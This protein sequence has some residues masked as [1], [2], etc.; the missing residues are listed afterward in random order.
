MFRVLIGL[1][2]LVHLCA[3]T[4]ATAAPTWPDETQIA[5]DSVGHRLLVF[6]HPH[7]RCSR[8]IANH[9]LGLIETARAPTK[10]TFVFYCPEG[11]SDKWAQNSVWDKLSGF[12]QHELLIDRGGVEAE[13]FNVESSGHCV[14]FD[15]G[16][17]LLFSGGLVADRDGKPSPQSVAT[18]RAHLEGRADERS[19]F[20]VIGCPIENG[21][22]LS[23]Y[24]FFTNYGH[25]MPRIHCLQTAQGRP[26]WP[27]ILV[28]I[29]LNVVILCG[30]IKIIRIWL[31][32][33]FAEERRDREP[34][35]LDLA[36]IF[37]FC[38]LSGYGVSTLI[39]FWPA[40]RLLAVLLL[41]LAIV[42][43]RFAYDLSPFEKS[44][45]MSR[46]GRKN[47]E[48]LEVEIAES[49]AREAAIREAY[50]ALQGIL[51]SLPS[52]VCILGV[53]GEII[54]ANA[55]SSQLPLMSGGTGESL[56]VNFLDACRAATGGCHDGATALADATEQIIREGSGSYNAEICCQ[57]G[58]DLL[59]YEVCVKPVKYHMTGATLVA[60]TDITKR[61]QAENEARA[62]RDEA[63]RLA[64][65]AKYTDNAVIITDNQV[66][67][68]W[69]NEGFTRLT[70]FTL[71]EVKGK[72]P[73][74]LLQGVGS[75]PATIELM[76]QRI[77]C[78]EGFD[79]EIVNYNKTGQ[80][81]WLAIEARPIQDTHGHVSK[82][83][84]IES[85]ITERKRRE[86]QL[87]AL[88]AELSEKHQVMEHRAFHDSLTGLPNRASILRTIQQ[89]ID[90]NDN[91][92]FALLFLDFDR[93]KLINDSLGHNAGDKL[94]QQIS[95]RLRNCLRGSDMVTSAR[96]GGDEFVVL[97]KD[98]P[99][100]DT[101]CIVAERLLQTFASSYQIG[102]STVH[103]T[104]SIGIVTN[105][106]GYRSADDMLRDAD[107]AMYEAKAKGKGCCVVFDR[108][109][110]ERADSRLKVECDLRRAILHDEFDLHYQ[111]IV[112][113]E[114]GHLVGVEAL[115]RWRHPGR[116]LVSPADFI[117]VAEE[118]GLIVSIGEFVLDEACRQF[119][120]WQTTLGDHAPRC[121]HI[122]ASR[123]QMLL[124]GFKD[125]VAERL[126]AHN[127][128]P[129]CLHIE[130]TESMIM[131][132]S[133]TTVNTMKAIREL[134]VKIDMDDFGTGY[135]SLSCL[136]NFPID[137][138]KIDRSFIDS[139]REVQEY[140]ALLH[141][142][143]VLA[144]N[145]H[146][147]VVAEGIETREQVATLQA[148][149]CDFGQGYFFSKP[150]PADDL[151][152]YA[153]RVGITAE[154][155]GG[156][157]APSVDFVYSNDSMTTQL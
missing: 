18:L 116:G 109:M 148:M 140:V 139:A 20:P 34:K 145:L 59:W 56:G 29:T 131:Q 155:R 134:G 53:Q 124:P 132:D 91:R 24:D 77:A 80:Q 153:R 95:E 107:V 94:L 40:Y 47:R 2:L 17:R 48:L 51:D 103:S 50:Q 81:Y 84:A 105:Q 36:W 83:I 70:G 52:H 74:Q 128:P 147:Q 111:P 97:L 90:N 123:L 5:H 98:L 151:E 127:V 86:E 11:E 149:G 15:K 118:T 71:E 69:V 82:F 85:D 130:V 9:V 89:V 114:S 54:Q 45:S 7:C 152:V 119:A 73:G 25:Y 68:E 122:N 144:N 101:A 41:L 32:C 66:R 76:R 157:V 8:N 55:N 156:D 14:L 112:S 129:H 3:W 38:G 43:W 16:Q 138:L 75:D 67:V 79:V 26:D 33:Y 113:L 12:G 21:A 87:A 6:I 135:S 44:F 61:V 88:N 46:V 30:Y 22:A 10:V 93:F 27:W 72:N 141:A 37:F 92:R 65:V 58:K 28:L 136:H 39:F 126:R 150:L 78:R 133:D 23:E 96:L 13:N 142:I 117:P 110:Y 100:W 137:T 115:V 31:K 108:S 104:A 102:S 154:P 4:P 120:S 125:L 99:D 42:T 64:L 49:I 143:L 106:H 146:L 121:I 60:Y 1:M 35:L 57:S 63:E 62:Q 19:V